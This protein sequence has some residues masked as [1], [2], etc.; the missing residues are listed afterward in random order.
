MELNEMRELALE[1][2]V[3][4]LEKINALIAGL[5]AEISGKPA[6][7]KARKWRISAEGRKRISEAQRKRWATAR[8]AS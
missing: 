2:L 3:A 5:K 1:A 7:A 8:K 6:R 4:R